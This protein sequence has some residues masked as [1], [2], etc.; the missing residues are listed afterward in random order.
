[1]LLATPFVLNGLAL[2]IGAMVS[3]SAWD[4]RSWM[5]VALVAIIVSIASAMVAWSLHAWLPARMIAGIKIPSWIA[6]AAFIAVAA[7]GTFHPSGTLA[8]FFGVALMLMLP[9]G[10]IAGLIA[11][12]I[13]LRRN[14]IGAPRPAPRPP[15][16]GG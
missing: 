14:R 4:R 10:A 5:I 6:H 1:M 15:G 13:V 2:L 8:G 3:M 7:T 11:L 9:A 16:L 12:A